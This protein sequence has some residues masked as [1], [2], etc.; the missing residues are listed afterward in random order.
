[1]PDWDAARHHDGYVARDVGVLEQEPGTPI[2]R[3]SH[4]VERHVGVQ[5]SPTIMHTQAQIFSA[6]WHSHDFP[7]VQ[8]DRLR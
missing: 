2:G 4:S 6:A 8:L 7:P 1:M 3:R 5:Y